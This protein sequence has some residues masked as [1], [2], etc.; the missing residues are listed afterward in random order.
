M[1]AEADYGLAKDQLQQWQEQIIKLENVLPQDSPWQQQRLKA[2][3]PPAGWVKKKESIIAKEEEKS[4]GGVSFDVFD[5]SGSGG[6]SSGG[7]VETAVI[8]AENLRLGSSFN[9]S[10]QLQ[11]SLSAHQLT[12]LLGL[13][14]GELVECVKALEGVRGGEEGQS[15]GDD[16]DGAANP[17]PLLQVDTHSAALAELYALVK[18]SINL[19]VHVYSALI[20]VLEHCVPVYQLQ[21]Q[22][23]TTITTTTTG[24]DD[25]VENEAL[26]LPS[27]L[28]AYSLVSTTSY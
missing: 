21:Q 23:G 11:A 1:S 20:K 8:E 24:C 26:F 13:Q 25:K 27:S 22:Q 5:N 3:L 28:R 6:Y 19:D 12:C 7:D 2:L 17:P 10:G 4:G 18:Q 15:V 16:D 14:Y 9:A